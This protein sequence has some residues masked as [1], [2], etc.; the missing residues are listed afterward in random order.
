MKLARARGRGR[1]G[2]TLVEMMV[3]IVIIG[4]MLSMITAAVIKGLWKGKEVRNRSDLSQFEVSLEQFKTTFKVGYPPS[5]IVLYKKFAFYFDAMQNYKDGKLGQDSVAFLTR[6]FPRLSSQNFSDFKYPWTYSIK[7]PNGPPITSIWVD[8]NGNGVLDDKGIY[9]EGDQCLVFFLGGIPGPSQATAGNGQPPQCLGFSTDPKNPA[10]GTADR[11]G[12]LFEFQS[13][14]L[15]AL[16][17][18]GGPT[19]SREFYSY[20]DTYGSGDGLG[21]KLSGQPYAYFSSGQK[22][23]DY[24]RYFTSAA[25]VSDCQSISPGGVWPYAEVV[26]QTVPSNAT[27]P[28]IARYLKPNSFQII[29]AGADNQFGSGS[30]PTVV[31]TQITLAPLWTATSAASV[32]VQDNP[33]YDDQSNFTGSLLG[34]GVDQ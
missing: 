2:F 7:D 10:A 17:Q 34:V 31:G 23:N 22:A 27:F 25:P 18:P 29:T 30:K 13:A 14:R 16:R 21:N 6:M 12:P 26:T 8:W 32:Y 28:P 20:L 11:I 19:Y 24:N 3:V 9:L 15:V 4:I 5:R 33:G 1:P